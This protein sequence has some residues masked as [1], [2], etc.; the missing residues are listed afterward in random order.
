MVAPRVEPVGAVAGSTD[1][2]IR[3]HR[4]LVTWD[5]D[6]AKRPLAVAGIAMPIGGTAL[7]GSLAGCQA[8][9]DRSAMASEQSSA[10]LN[11]PPGVLDTRSWQCPSELP[12]DV[13][14]GQLDL[15]L[16]WSDPSSP[17]TVALAYAVHRASAEHVGTLTFNPGGPGTS[18][19]DGL[20]FMLG[21]GPPALALPKQ[22]VDHFD[23]V[24]RHPRGSTRGNSGR[25]QVP[26]R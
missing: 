5:R 26:T 8:Q 10:G 16:E 9:A 23:F 14:C 21:A 15:P 3:L 17:R 11:Q 7:L 6:T 22:I 4:M 18:G 2:R 20:V 12:A 1:A 19:I 13:S 25:G 24:A